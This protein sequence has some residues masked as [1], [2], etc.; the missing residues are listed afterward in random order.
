MEI[1]PNEV[2]D[3][4]IAASTVVKGVLWHRALFCSLNMMPP[5]PTRVLIDNQGVL[6]LIKSEQINDCT[7]HIDTKFQH[8][9]DCEAMGDIKSEH[10]STEHQVADIMTKSLGKKKF[11]L[12]RGKI[13]VKL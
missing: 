13:E 3:K 8:I 9:C 2:C 4:F 10:V 7:K 1:H 11:L 5:D 12:F 6:D